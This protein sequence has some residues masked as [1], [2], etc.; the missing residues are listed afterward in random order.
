MITEDVR[1]LEWFPVYGPRQAVRIKMQG[2]A[3]D[4]ARINKCDH[5]WVDFSVP[6]EGNGNPNWPLYAQCEQCGTYRG[7]LVRAYHVEDKE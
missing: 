7:G 5:D 4:V 6:K 2:S 1:P 3:R